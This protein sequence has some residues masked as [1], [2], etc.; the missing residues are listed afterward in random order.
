MEKGSLE[1]RGAD[2]V[3]VVGVCIAEE[4]G[5]KAEYKSGTD[6]EIAVVVVRVCEAI[7]VA[8]V[9]SVVVNQQPVSF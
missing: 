3:G 1:I 5:A 2:K 9:A 8:A 4:F 6:N 7:G